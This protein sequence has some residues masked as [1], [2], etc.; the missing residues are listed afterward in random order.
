[1]SRSS[2]NGGY[3]KDLGSFSHQIFNQLA[4]DI[5]TNAEQ[6]VS[7]AFQNE[8]CRSSTGGQQPQEQQ[9]QPPDHHRPTT[10]TTATNSSSASTPSRG[11]GHH[12]TSSSTSSSQATT[13]DAVV[14]DWLGQV[15]VRV[16]KRALGWRARFCSDICVIICL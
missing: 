7:A 4:S 15:S 12:R 14:G 13:P 6:L 9:Q 2:G 11:R 1:M 10:D 8:S 3:F 16:L 5:R